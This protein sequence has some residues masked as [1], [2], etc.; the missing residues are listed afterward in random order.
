M[1][2][3]RDWSSATFGG[4][5]HVIRLTLAD[6]D[7]AAAWLA[8]LP[9]AELRVFGR[10]VADLAVTEVSRRDGGVSAAIEALTIFE[11]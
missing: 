6:D 8:A 10:L 7:R 9:E 11:G 3:S 1:A 5:R 2:I 4:E